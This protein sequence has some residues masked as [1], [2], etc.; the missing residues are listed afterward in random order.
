M[1]C[2][3]STNRLR[4]LVLLGVAIA[5]SSCAPAAITAAGVAVDLGLH[6]YELATRAQSGIAQG[7][8]IQCHALAAREAALVAKGQQ[9]KVAA[10]ER[11]SGAAALCNPANPPPSDPIAAAFWLGTVLAAL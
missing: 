6:V 5:L 7:I 1:Q 3:V 8:E 11:W 9:D 10:I 4:L 2:T